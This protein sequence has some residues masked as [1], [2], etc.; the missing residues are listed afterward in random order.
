MPVARK[1]S[2]GRHMVSSLV[3][4]RKFHDALLQAEGGKGK[5]GPYLRSEAPDR[6]GVDVTDKLRRGEHLP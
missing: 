4:D 2:L 6:R 5:A 3:Q 1:P